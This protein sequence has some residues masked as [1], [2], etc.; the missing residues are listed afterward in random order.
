MILFLIILNWILKALMAWLM[1]LL[2][3]W[4]GVPEWAMIA[5]VAIGATETK[6]EIE[7]TS[8]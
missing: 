2:A 3:N 7:R 1:Y 6:I 4:L 8:R 5:M